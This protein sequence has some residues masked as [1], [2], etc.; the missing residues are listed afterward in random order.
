M[1]RYYIAIILL[2]ITI[3]I[4]PLQIRPLAVPDETRYGEIPR[5]MITTGNWVAPRL[6][7]IRYFEKPV[8]GYWLNAASMKI[9]G[10]NAFAIRLPSA[11]SVGITALLLFF[12][13]GRFAG[14]YTT[15][16]LVSAVY[17]TFIEVFGIGTFC[18]LDSV[19]TMFITAVMFFFWY[20]CMNTSFPK[21]LLFLLLCGLAAGLGFLTKGLVAIVVPAVAIVPFLVWQRKTY[22]ILRWIWLPAL[23]AVAVVMPW[24]IMIH[25][26]EPDFWHFFIWHEH[27]ERFLHPGDNQHARPF[28]YF[29]PILLVGLMPWIFNLPAIVVGLKTKGLTEPLIRYAYCW[30]IFPFLFFSACKGKLGTYILPCF[31]PL[32]LLI[33]SALLVYFRE[34][35]NV[36]KFVKGLYFSTILVVTITLAII[37]SQTLI[38]KTTIYST[39]ETWKWLLI[40]AGLIFYAGDLLLVC[41]IKNIK[42][43]LICCSLAPL[44]LLWGS[45]FIIPNSYK[46]KYM[47]SGI[48]QRNKKQISKD[49]ILVSNSRLAP[50]VC[51]YYHRSN[52]LLVKGGGEFT[53]GLKYPDSAMRKISVNQLAELMR[54][55]VAQKKSPHRNIIFFI[56]ADRYKRWEKRFPQPVF[57]DSSPGYVFA[58]YTHHD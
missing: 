17:M 27:I 56:D 33:A 22:G 25:L 36:E 45:F 14:G 34:K 21:R 48:L 2:Y 31:A 6:D 28:W 29:L 44:V 11:L 12:L 10:Q 43:K 5:E 37:L 24:A 18:V 19:L 49:D 40:V 47:P 23:V 26:R 58:K 51:W 42:N 38:T 46:A 30:F 1:K 32:A 52:V 9:F 53:Y 16:L 50:A 41:R 3:Y 55:N 57:V 4:T 54:K 13:V 15:G 8:L 35:C 7:G 20:A 39:S